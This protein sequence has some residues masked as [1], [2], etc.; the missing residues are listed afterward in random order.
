[1]LDTFFL[2]NAFLQFDFDSENNYVFLQSQAQEVE[3][4]CYTDM[5]KKCLMQLHC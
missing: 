2:M 5:A 1:M 3:V 4:G